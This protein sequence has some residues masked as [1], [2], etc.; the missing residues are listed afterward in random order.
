MNAPL[1]SPRPASPV[2]TVSPAKNA[3]ERYIESSLRWANLTL[4]LEMRARGRCET[5]FRYPEEKAVHLTFENLFREILAD[6]L[7]L[8][9]TCYGKFVKNPRK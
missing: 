7:W 4:A 1:N 8:C 5:C 9:N 2:V 3:Y 6:L